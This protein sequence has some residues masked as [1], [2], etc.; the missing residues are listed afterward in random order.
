MKN[1]VS[2]MYFALAICLCL[3][4]NVTNVWAQDDL[5]GAWQATE[6]WGNNSEDGDWELKDLQPSLYIFLDG[7]YSIMLVTGEKARPL[8]KKDATRSS[9]SDEE[10]R[11]IFMPFIANS[12][13]YEVKGS[14]I[15]TKPM[16]ALWPNF[17]EGESDTFQYRFEN[18]MLVL[19]DEG[20]DWNWTAK[21]KR[22]E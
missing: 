20:E 3:Q 11:S 22:L 13:T 7:Y 6:A 8:M 5:N 1:L 17:M 21:F 2:I 4:F 10:M 18:D 16:V 19:S 9:I 12:G 14:S 15:T